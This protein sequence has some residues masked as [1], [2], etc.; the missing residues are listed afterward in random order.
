MRISVTGK[1]VFA[2]I[3]IVAALASC[4][5][6]STTGTSS[7]EP[8]LAFA[9]QTAT[10]SSIVIAPLPGDNS[11]RANGVNDA[12]E[13]VGYSQGTS[14]MRAFVTLGGVVTQLPGTT[15][16]AL[17]ISNGAT[18]YVVGQVGS[19][20]ARWTIAGNSPGAP[21]LLDAGGAEYGS[22]RAVNDAGAAAGYAGASGAVWDAAGI[23]TLVST[24]AGFTRGEGRGIDNAGNGA[25]VFSRPEAGWE[26]G[27][28]AA[29]LRLANG[30]LIALPPL[31]G[32]V[33]TYANDVGPAGG[34][35]VRVAGSS[36]T[37]PGVSRGVRWTVDVSTGAITNVEARSE[38]S[39][40]LA[41]ADDGAT[42]GFTEGSNGFKSNAFRWHGTA[43]LL[44]SPPKGGKLGK[45]WAIS[46]NGLRVAGEVMQ[47]SRRAVVWTIL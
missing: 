42:A 34:N 15:G 8:E 31:T 35:L 5:P 39:H 14:Q 26:G 17:A 4:Q 1:P 18:R 9:R 6:D 2:T 38:H 25:F 12:G 13:V 43:L 3:A 22:A 23:L 21:A 40:A 32:D 37:V 33:V 27:I 11:S 41:V 10:H 46:P 16:H 36:H 29:Y 30:Q 45:A 20:P 24:P 7:A 47:P 19:V 44:L 28:A